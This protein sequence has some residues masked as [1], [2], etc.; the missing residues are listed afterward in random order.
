VAGVAAAVVLAAMVMVP[1]AST[2]A[3]SRWLMPWKNIQRYTFADLE[4]IP[5]QLVVLFGESSNLDAQLTPTSSWQ[6]QNGLALVNGQG[7]EAENQNGKF[8]FKIPPLSQAADLQVRV[9]DFRTA[10]N[11][12]P[13]MRPELASV[14]AQI[15]L[16]EYL[17]REHPVVKDIRGGSI[18]VVDGSELA[19]HGSATRDL[20]KAS[21]DQRPIATAGRMLTTSPLSIESTSNFAIDWEDELGLSP[22]TPFALSVRVNKDSQPSL[23]C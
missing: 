3:F 22:K 11:V 17:K 10:V 18:S 8:S 7:I 20:V 21:L 2:N 12:E 15:K 5:D 16:P 4:A 1:L 13:V 23:A 14:T 6:P 19:I 9:G